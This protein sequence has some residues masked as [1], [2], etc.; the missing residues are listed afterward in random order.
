MEDRGSRMED[1]GSRMED[2][3]SWMEDRG[4][5]MLPVARTRMKRERIGHF[6]LFQSK[7][8][9]HQSS[10]VNPLPLHPVARHLRGRTRMKRERIGHFFLFQSKIINHQSS[11]HPSSSG[12]APSPRAH[13]HETRT[14][15][16]A[17]SPTRHRGARASRPLLFPKCGRDAR[18]PFFPIINLSCHSREAT[19][20]LKSS[21]INRQS[22][23]HPF[24]RHV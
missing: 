4:S 6:F 7:I 1:R 16:S 21:I 13:A 23:H 18:A 10:I 5:W 3:G 20:D 24:H 8:N 11:I 2:R 9:N 12:S 14:Q 19:A 17:V 22:L 15:V